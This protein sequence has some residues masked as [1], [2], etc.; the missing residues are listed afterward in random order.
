MVEL[1]REP[2]ELVEWPLL[3]P[4]E[5]NFCRFFSFL[6]FDVLGAR[7]DSFG[8]DMVIVYLNVD[9]DIYLN[10]HELDCKVR[11]SCLKK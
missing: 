3:F 4:S 2:Q 9:E 5:V 11:E 8:D 6:N 1:H 7:S 10:V